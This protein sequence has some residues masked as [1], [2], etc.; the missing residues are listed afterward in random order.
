[1]SKLQDD[2]R[3]TARMAASGAPAPVQEAPSDPRGL[4]TVVG[5][6]LR[7]VTERFGQAWNHFWFTPSDAFVLSVVRVCTGLIGLYTVL[8]YTADLGLLLGPDGLLAWDTIAEMRGNY[9]SFSYFAWLSTPTQVWIAHLAGL[10]V[11]VMFT[12]GLFTRVTTVLSLV[13]LL[14]YFQRSFLVTSEME[15]VLT[16]VVFYLCFAPTGAYL[17]LD[18]LIARRRTASAS[19]AESDPAAPHWSVTVATRLIQV[20]LTIV[21]VMMLLAQLNERAWWDGTAL[22][23]ILGRQESAMTNLT[24]LHVHPWVVNAWTHSFI[25]FEAAFALLA[26]NRLAA[27]LLVA[28]SIPVWGLMAV[29]T[30]LAP[31]AAMMIVAG[32]TFLAPA[33]LRTLL[34]C[35]GLSALVK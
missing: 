30:G 14:S 6:Y 7:E 18:R 16:F 23:W 29:A 13:V 27:P 12:V 8:T 34:G 35:C 22:W 2:R 21:Y 15:P 25:L 20:H 33:T 1:M 28:L 10:L 3:V 11:L 5:D 24:W 32:L 4:T 31:L 19:T 9:A 17:S 26:W